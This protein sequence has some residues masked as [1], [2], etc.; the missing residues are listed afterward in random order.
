[1][2]RLFKV[3]R[4]IGLVL[5]VLIIV[6][7]AGGAWFLRRPWPQVDGQITAAGLSAP[8]QIIRDKWGVP[9]IYADNDHDLFFAQGY[10]HAQDRLWQME[11]NRRTG[12]GTLSAALGAGLLETDQLI[13]TM[14]WPQA[15]QKDWEALDDDSRAILTAYS[16]GVNAYIETHGDRLP[17]DFTI[18]G[19]K[20]RPWTPIDTLAWGKVLMYSLGGN[21]RLELLRAQMIAEK[22]AQVT[23]ELLP[24]YG[25]DMPLI[26]PPEAQGYRDF[27]NQKLSG[28]NGIDQVFG[29]PGPVN[30]SNNW[31]VSGSRTESGKPLLANDTHLNLGMPGIWYQNGIQGGRFNSVGF[32]FPGVPGVVI[33]HND[34]IAWGVSNVN[35]DVQD[36]YIEK[37]NDPNNPT[38]YEFEGKWYDLEVSTETIEVKKQAPETLKIMRTRHGPIIS[39]VV[40]DTPGVPGPIAI[41]WTAL[42]GVPQFQSIIQL[43]LAKNWDEFRKALSYWEAPSQN[44][45]YA[46]VDGNIGYQTPG[47]IP[48][49][50]KG[51]QGLV[52]V[53][54]WTGEYE[55]QGFIPFDELPS[56]LNPS[57]GFL[58]TANNKIV[59]DDYPYSLAY[60]WDPGY[61]AKRIT[62]LLAAD[63]SVTIEDIQKIQ[64]DTYSLAAD[65][66]APYLLAIQPADDAQS[67]ALEQVRSWDKRY[68]VDR[69]GASI[70]QVWYWFLL[71]NTLNDDLGT[72]LGDVY[73]AGD[74]ER[75]GTFQLPLM[76]KLM[77]QAD[78]A[79]FDD[80]A[81]PQVETR[82]DIVRRSLSDALAWL[83]E[84]YGTD[85]SRW[86]WGTLHTM[87]FRSSPLGQSGIAP[88]EW[89]YTSRTVPA[90]GDNFTVDAGSFRYS[91]PFIMVHG[92]SQRDIID[93]GN[94]SNSLMIQPTGQ[95]GHVLHPHNRDFID[96][97]QNVEYHSMLFDRAQVEANAEGTLTLNPR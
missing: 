4:I 31:V 43:N 24:P 16:E 36:L 34:R 96:A 63:D 18:L 47:R 89:L 68:E 58:A 64:A 70:Y 8:A 2:R 76:T 85:Q 71:K 88:L 11:M 67:R 92:A 75:H 50:A 9:H 72:E 27:K 51:H 45:V 52:P 78:N 55:W 82:D 48:I 80:K 56:V 93:L 7:A 90:R 1:M 23:Q 37:L 22:G 60:E 84:N 49:R 74:Y 86:T 38:Q 40:G 79:W 35:P 3:L 28:L 14:G 32:T 21:Y 73:L 65:A 17:L 29:E 53:P 57:T 94:F 42:E 69:V 20:P 61:R 30:G 91:R 83:N 25:P 15:A 26:I 13:R 62:D 46:D 39:G 95:S 97:W 81:T 41:R 10:A 6:A 77:A 12:T 59:S 44:F 87:T 33:G 66:L 54:G 19:I 5:L